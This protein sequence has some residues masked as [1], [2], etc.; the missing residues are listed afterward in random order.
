MSNALNLLSEETFAEKM[1]TLNGILADI[2]E[3]L[4]GNAEQQ[5]EPAEQ[6]VGE[7]E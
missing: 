1:D 5:E 3:V 6:E 7:N 2:L 4:S